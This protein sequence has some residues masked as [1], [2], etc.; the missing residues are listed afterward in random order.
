MLNRCSPLSPSRGQ[1]RH[2]ADHGN[3][4][5]YRRVCVHDAD[6]PLASVSGITQANFLPPYHATMSTV[7]VMLASSARATAQRQS[8]PE[9]WP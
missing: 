9:R 5:G 3:V 4:S 7:R 6:A 1:S 8:S 2:A